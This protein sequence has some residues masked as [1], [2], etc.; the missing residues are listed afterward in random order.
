MLSILLYPYIV[1]MFLAITSIVIGCY[2]V[3]K[4]MI[5]P[6]HIKV[7][8][9]ITPYLSLKFKGFADELVIYTTCYGQQLYFKCIQGT[10]DTYSTLYTLPLRF[11]NPYEYVMSGTLDE[12]IT[13]LRVVTDLKATSSIINNNGISVIMDNNSEHLKK[14]PIKFYDVGDE[15]RKRLGV[16]VGL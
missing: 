5:K 1:V 3:Y 2:L 9:T 13:H 6:Y 14:L 8:D 10:H 4:E 7:S 12:A 16:K 15:V 11:N